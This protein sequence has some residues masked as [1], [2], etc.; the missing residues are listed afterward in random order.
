M[1]KPLI[2]VIVP[3]YKVEEYLE[4]CVC[5]LTSQT[6]ENLEILL[7]DDGS[8]DSCGAMCD[9]F[10]REDPR[11][12]VIHKENGGLSSARNAGIDQARGE[13]LGFVDS[14]D[15][16]EKD[17]YEALMAM[18]REEDLKLVCGG[19]YDVRHETGEK[20]V[21]LCPPRREVI[22]GEELV[23]RIFLWDNID[24]AAWD[25]LYHRSLFA[26]IRYPL[27]MIV[28]DVP[29]TYRIAL[30]AGKAGMVSKPIYNY[31]HRPGSITTGAISPRIFH[32]PTHTKAIFEDIRANHPE[33]K[34]QAEYLRVRS[35]VYILQTLENAAPEEQ[36]KYRQEYRQYKKHL[37]SHMAFLLTSSIPT[38]KER[39]TWLLL[40]LGIYGPAR[41]ARQT[42]RK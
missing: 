20:T 7:V 22:S 18:A 26:S 41:R 21:G 34:P 25:K 24:S 17:A 37:G 2:S 42:L 31:Y 38:A 4:R 19:R 39:L 27:G 33:L 12:R 10:A 23:K 30:L 3:V 29:T 1:E 16:L 15:F 5:S 36:Q 8:P 35:L 32:F 13:Y 14:D 40:A 6:Y 11:I 28:E 9:S